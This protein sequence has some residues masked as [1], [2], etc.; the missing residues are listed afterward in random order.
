MSRPGWVAIFLTLVA[1]LV[2]GVFLA[3]D[4]L[5]SGDQQETIIEKPELETVAAITT[6]LHRL[7]VFPA[8][9]RYA[10]PR[11]VVA[12]TEG[13]ITKTPAEGVEVS[14]GDPIL[15]IDGE[16]VF[17]FYGER[18]M[19]RSLGPTPD[20]S[21]IEGPDV[22]QLE[23][24]LKALGYLPRSD[25]DPVFDED[26]TRLIRNWRADSGLDR[27]DSIELGRIVYVEGPVR[28]GRS[29][30]EL[31]APVT[32]GVAIVEVSEVTQ[33]VRMELPVDRRDRVSVGSEVV[34][35]LPGD[36]SATGSVQYVGSVVVSPD[37]RR[38]A[39]FVEVTVRLDDPLL[40]TQFHGYPVEVEIVADRAA[41]VLAVPIKALVALSEGGY[42]VEVE[43][44][45]GQIDLVGVETGMYADG[46]VEIRGDLDDG[47]LVRAPK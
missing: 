12:V 8:T 16:P 40:G 45:D 31:G 38:G 34:V 2:V 22:E 10:N 21:P 37:D 17:I 5:A 3:V 27:S 15:E 42:A 35:R 41:G 25:P 4:R 33:E 46:L 44:D 18:P 32:P 14:R 13:I 47:D 36:L 11:H 20:E 24:N 29:L 23:L 9:L 30:V 6:D 28:V 26:T 19:W 43:R 7:E 1:V 39:D